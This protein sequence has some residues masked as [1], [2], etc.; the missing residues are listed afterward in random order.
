MTLSELQECQVWQQ[1]IWCRKVRRPVSQ[2]KNPWTVLT[3]I[4]LR[5]RLSWA[6]VD[7]MISKPDDCLIH[8]WALARKSHAFVIAVLGIENAC[9]PIT[10]PLIYL[11]LHLCASKFDHGVTRTTQLR[12]LTCHMC[13]CVSGQELCNVEPEGNH[14]SFEPLGRI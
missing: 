4:L 5:D 12:Q 6:F 10:T 14:M 1:S 8:R 3:W 7:S 11:V 13:E 9:K 2:A